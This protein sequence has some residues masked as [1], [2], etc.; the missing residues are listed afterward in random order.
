[1]PTSEQII[2]IARLFLF[3]RETGG[4]NKGRWVG[5]FQKL[6]DGVPG[7]SWCCYFVCVVL[8]IAFGGF[9]KS[10]IG[11]HGRVQDVYE[12][13][14]SNGWVT[15]KPVAGDLFVYVDATGHA[16]H[17]GFAT[18]ASDYVIVGIAGNTSN[19]GKSSNGDGV[20]EHAVF[21]R[22]FIHYPRGE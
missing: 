17:I 14:R 13:A 6:C 16:H 10:P 9:G 20:Y 21:P 7:D 15:D 3:V 11:M 4:Q 18:Y 5:A 19:D 2:S 1:V 8:A 22:V 12:L